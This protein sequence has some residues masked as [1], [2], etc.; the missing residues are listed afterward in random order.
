MRAVTQEMQEMIDA[1]LCAQTIG[2]REEYNEGIA[3]VLSLHQ[4]GLT[5]ME[6][7]YITGFKLAWISVILDEE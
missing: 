1:E 3:E 4:A 7:S 6:I 2:D 5:K